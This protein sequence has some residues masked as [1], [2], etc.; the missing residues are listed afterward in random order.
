MSPEQE[1]RLRVVA[2]MRDIPELIA[3]VE[4]SGAIEI[5]EDVAAALAEIDEL[6]GD[7]ALIRAEAVLDFV[8]R[9]NSRA[10]SDMLAGNPVEGAHHRAIEAELDAT[11]PA[12]LEAR[13][14]AQAERGFIVAEKAARC[15]LDLCS[16][17]GD[18]EDERACEAERIARSVL[19]ALDAEGRA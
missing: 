5:A 7:A 18:D 13:Q 4:F 12:S 1:Q 19:A 16:W 15:A 14:K 17:M 9:V 2:G 3:Y 11:A 6:R 10:E 8:A